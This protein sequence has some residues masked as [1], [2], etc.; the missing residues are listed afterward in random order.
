[1]MPAHRDPKSGEWIDSRGR[2]MFR[3]AVYGADRNAPVFAMAATP[4]AAIKAAYT[5]GLIRARRG[6]RA[7]RDRTLCDMGCS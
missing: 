2:V 5:N 3:W 6:A 1:M 7:E 4:D